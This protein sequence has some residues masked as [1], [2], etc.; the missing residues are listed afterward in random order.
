MRTLLGLSAI[1]LRVHC[2][3]PRRGS[4]ERLVLGNGGEA[5]ASVGLQEQR[6]G[7]RPEDA[8]SPLKLRSVDGQVGLMNEFV[9]VRSIKWKARDTERDGRTDGIARGLHLEPG[10]GHGAPDPFCDLERLLSG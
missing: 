8:I 6:L 5:D 1:H 2:Q 7:A 9:C 10:L 4:V 3:G